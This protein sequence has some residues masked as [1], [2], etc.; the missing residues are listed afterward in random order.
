MTDHRVRT[1]ATAS[2]PGRAPASD[3]L[4]N[5][6]TGLVIV[7]DQGTDEFVVATG[8]AD[9]DYA[10]EVDVVVPTDLAARRGSAEPAGRG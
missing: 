1:S 9:S 2:M 5:P 6:L 7:I 4:G 3:R 8:S 10:F